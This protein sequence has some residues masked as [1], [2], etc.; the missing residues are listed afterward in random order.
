MGLSTSCFMYIGLDA[1]MHMAEECH[2]PEK[3][4]PRTI[5]AAISIGFLTGFP[6]AVAMLYGLTDIDAILTSTG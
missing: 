4:V 3:T 5:M 6:F 2:Q 1:S